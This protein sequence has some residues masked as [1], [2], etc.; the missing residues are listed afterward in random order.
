MTDY[1]GT[2]SYSAD[3]P[4]QGDGDEND[5]YVFASGQALVS[6]SV[7][8][9]FVSGSMDFPSLKT[10]GYAPDDQDGDNDAF[11]NSATG[12]GIIT[13]T[14][15]SFSTGPINLNDGGTVT[16]KGHFTDSTDTKIVG[17]ATIHESGAD[18]SPLN[19]TVPVTFASPTLFTP[20][21]DTLN[22][23]A[24][25]AGQK[26]ALVYDSADPYD[27]LAGNDTV[28]LPNAAHYQL[29]GPP[30]PFT[31]TWNPATTFNAGPGNDTIIIPAGQ[32][33]AII[34]GDAGTDIV[35]YTGGSAFGSPFKFDAATRTA[36]YGDYTITYNGNTVDSAGKPGVQVTVTDAKANISDVLK[37]VEYVQLNGKNIP[38]EA[39][40]VSVT[41]NGLGSGASTLQ[42][43]LDGQSMGNENIYYDPTLP[44][45][46]GTGSYQAIF[47]T[48]AG[49]AS[50]PTVLELSN[51]VT[52]QSDFSNAE[53]VQIHGGNS[54]QNS[55]GCIVGTRAAGTALGSLIGTVIPTPIPGILGK[56]KTGK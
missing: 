45:Q 31:I 11:S 19:I 25:T 18:G 4:S 24:L 39:I 38:L 22:F 55:S 6:L 21:P 15:S 12:G 1:L 9:G 36:T 37:N 33:S 32:S 35:R 50:N 16:F 47:R 20:G 23:N 27:A 28:T 3:L 7:G 34:D 49:V 17:S 13:G 46:T 10:S 56:S 8:V 26:F 42:W 41:I 30:L 51:C 5:L 29:T 52:G 14:T 48:N 44:P 40:T 43:F 53:Y 2:I 54:S